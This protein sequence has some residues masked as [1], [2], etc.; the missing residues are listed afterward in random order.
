MAIAATSVVCPS[1][2]WT[3]AITG[4]RVGAGDRFGGDGADDARSRS[5]RGVLPPGGVR[6]S[7]YRAGGQDAEVLEAIDRSSQG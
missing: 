3:V 7:T 4:L 1:C 6:G 2:Q 5:C